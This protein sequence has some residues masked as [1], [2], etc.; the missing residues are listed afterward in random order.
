LSVFFGEKKEHI[1][2]KKTYRSEEMGDVKVKA[3]SPL[4][5]RREK[6][7]RQS[8]VVTSSSAGAPVQEIIKRVVRVWLF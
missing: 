1:M 8:A 2:A 5:K 4:L 6:K 3:S 7:F